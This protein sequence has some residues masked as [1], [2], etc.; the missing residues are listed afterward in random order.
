[1]TYYQDAFCRRVV[2]RDLA[3]LRGRGVAAASALLSLVAFAV[4]VALP[5]LLGVAAPETPSVEDWRGN[6][7]SL[8][9]E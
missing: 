7:A 6:S 1:M 4:L 5:L 2:S 3:T 8:P 9:S